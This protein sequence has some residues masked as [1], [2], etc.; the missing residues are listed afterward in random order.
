M[1]NLE[2]V[3]R[4]LAVL[5]TWPPNV[6]HLAELTAAQDQAKAEGAGFWKEGGL[7]MTPKDW[8]AGHKD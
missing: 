6:A 7:A 3:R 5:Y 8:R 4:G 1:L 2:L